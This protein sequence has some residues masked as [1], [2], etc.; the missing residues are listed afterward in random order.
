MIIS[1]GS[2]STVECQKDRQQEILFKTY[3]YQN[4]KGQETVYHRKDCVEIS[5]DVC[6]IPVGTDNYEEV[7]KMLKAQNNGKIAPLENR[8]FYET[9]EV[10]KDYYDG[11]LS[12][13]EVK[14][15][16][17]EY[18]YHYMGK[19]TKLAG[20]EEASDGQRAVMYTNYETQ[21]ATRYLAGLYEHFSRANTRNACAQ[22][23]EEGKDLLESNGI[24]VNGAYYYN[25]DWYYACE[26]MQ[27]LF[28][29][30]ADELADEFNAEHVDFKYVEENT[31]FT[32]DG[33]I[34][35]NGVW[36]AV[37][38]QINHAGPV[39]G[40]FLDKNMAPPRGFIY[41]GS[42]YG[43]NGKGNPEGVREAIKNKNKEYASRTLL[44]VETY[45]AQPGG[46][47]LFDTKNYSSL[48][49]W[50]EEDPGQDAF[51]FLKNFGIRWN[52]KGNR[53]ECMF[54]GK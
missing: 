4:S 20:T 21:L 41:C 7:R 14:N 5:M 13:D 16:F 45:F 27:D 43:W 50:K 12:R 37:K 8:M 44:L 39:T 18:F 23:N 10:M 30:T 34:T 42:G 6:E 25:A 35:Y 1:E 40:G 38:W 46:S 29:Q 49:E 9:Y 32:L 11:K 47:L 17:K 33:G 48:S 52:Y 24:S 31:R 53:W 28:R 54:A 19:E 36:D 26:E 2:R 15:I 3:S 22:N 51:S